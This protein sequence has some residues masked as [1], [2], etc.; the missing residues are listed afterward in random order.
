LRNASHLAHR[1]AFVVPAYSRWQLP[2]YGIGLTL[3][4][5]LAGRDG[6]GRSRVLSGG[7]VREA[8]PG[9][10]QT[11]FKGGILYY[12]G[13]F[14]DA[15]LAIAILRTLLDL[16]GVALNYAPVTRLL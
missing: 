8:L 14:D 10:R 5:L 3:Y 11:G 7:R 15:R 13:Q 2:Y 6:L 16:G 1:R 12:D 9:V 4:D